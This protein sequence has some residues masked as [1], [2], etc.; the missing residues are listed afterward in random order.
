VC[1][2]VSLFAETPYQRSS[3]CQCLSIAIHGRWAASAEYWTASDRTRDA[4]LD[5][6]PR[7]QLQSVLICTPQRQT[8]PTCMLR[9]ILT[10]IAAEGRPADTLS[11]SAVAAREVETARQPLHRSLRRASITSWFTMSCHEHLRKPT[12]VVR[13][14]LS[15]RRWSPRPSAGVYSNG[16]CRLRRR[17]LAVSMQGARL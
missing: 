9:R 3:S 16:C 2:T 12:R 6:L 4:P 7:H 1:I 11:C 17:L 15:P 10:S 14:L 5:P 13:S 8:G